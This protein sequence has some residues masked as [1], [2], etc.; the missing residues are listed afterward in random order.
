MV[1]ETEAQT[2][3]VGDSNNLIIKYYAAINNNL[4]G[5]RLITWLCYK[6]KSK[7]FKEQLSNL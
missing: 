1:E 3:A 4:S 6:V 7:K 2:I 5:K